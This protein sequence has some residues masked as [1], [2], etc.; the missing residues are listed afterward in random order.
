[1]SKQ[2]RDSHSPSACLGDKSV[3]NIGTTLQDVSSVLEDTPTVKVQTPAEKSRPRGGPKRAV[4]PVSWPLLSRIG[5]TPQQRNARVDG[6][7]GSDANTLLS[8]DREKILQLWR[9]K[10]GETRDEDLSA[11]LPVMLGC[12]TEPFNRQWYERLSRTSVI[13]SGSSFTCE[14]H[15]WRKCTLDGLVD[16]GE[17]VFEAKHTSAFA[18]ADEVLE[19]YM[20]QLQHNM[21]VTRRDRA[22]LSVIFGNH[23]YE[24]F[25]IAADWLYQ[26][27]LFEVEAAFWDCVVTG[28]EPIAANVPAAPRPV[29]VR[30]VCF[31]GH[32]AWAFAAVDWL[33]LREAAKKH[34]A[35]VGLIKSLVDEDVC[36]AFG[37]GIEAKRSK[38][39]AITI[40]EFAQ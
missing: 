6:I 19:R 32:N 40:R 21:A 4:K 38:S 2:V 34:A 35:A 1:M 5:L 15:E 7:G 3:D 30:E 22:V 28:R 29:G 12:W 11:V 13:A 18:K 27:E 39:G 10:R 16:P 24:V 31:E 25:E 37:H 23:K 14:E 9:V 26:Q 17:A 8:G 33:D 36:R 20:P